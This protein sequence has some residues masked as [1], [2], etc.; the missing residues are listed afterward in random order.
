VIAPHYEFWEPVHSVLGWRLTLLCLIAYAIFVA[1]CYI[2]WEK[3]R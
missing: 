3:F 2:A 1:I